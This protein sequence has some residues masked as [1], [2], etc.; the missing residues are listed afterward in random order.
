MYTVSVNLH[1][2]DYVH[3]LRF[4]FTIHFQL[5]LPD[6]DNEFRFNDASTHEGNLRQ[7]GRSTWFRIETAIIKRH[8]CMKIKH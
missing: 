8:I 6:D 3:L 2:N 7:N 4:V 5:T 1:E